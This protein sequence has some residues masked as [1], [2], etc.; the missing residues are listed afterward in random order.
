MG[1]QMYKICVDKNLPNRK[2]QK[3]S[4][5]IAENLNPINLALETGKKWA[6]GTEIKCVF[7]EG[8]VVQKAK[9]E[10]EAHK[11]EQYANIKFKFVE[12]EDADIRISFDTS[13]GSWS[14]IGTDNLLVPS[15]E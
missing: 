8:T 11:W 3:K 12:S 9:V 6:P 5:K 1:T 14:Y 15:Y 7:L 4:D 2:L 13:S 10:R